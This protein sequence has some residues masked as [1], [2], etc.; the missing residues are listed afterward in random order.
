MGS[1]NANILPATTGLNV[2]SDLQRWNIYPQ[3]IVLP[4]I[5]N[6]IGSVSGTPLVALSSS[7]SMVTMTLVGN[8]SPTISG[9]P[10]VV[11]FAI[12]QNGTG[13]YTLTWPTGTVNGMTVGA[14]PNQISYQLF[15]WDGTNL[16]A[17]APGLLNP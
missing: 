6:V 10:G 5:L 8:A 17:M 13:G 11:I 7:I 14:L 3:N 4:S 16:T 2:G 15:A 9:P 1:F 12:S